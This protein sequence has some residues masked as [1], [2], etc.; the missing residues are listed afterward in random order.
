MRLATYNILHGRAVS[1][2]ASH[3]SESVADDPELLLKAIGRLDA[4]V[5]GLQEVD[6]F[7]PRSRTL[8]QTRLIAESLEAP[9]WR[10]VPTVIGTPGGRLGFRSATHTEIMESATTAAIPPEPEYGISLISRFPVSS[11]RVKVFPPAPFSLPLMV[12]SDRKP[13][14]VRVRDEQRAAIAAQVE[15]PLGRL[16]VVTAHLSF[17]PGFN[18]RQLRRLR[19]WIADMPRPLIL[20]GDFNLPGSVPRTTS[21]LT[22]LVT[23]PTFPS[24]RPRIQFDHIMADGFDE[25]EIEH[26]RS[27]VQ[28]WATGVSDHCAVT[29]D[30][31]PPLARFQ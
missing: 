28:T 31:P 16:T 29:V 9:E 6:K 13:Q 14:M 23:Q 27:S 17:V 24:Y 15:S 20:M 3:L 26:M 12:Q 11:W 21:R 4:D 2:S 22:E 7:Q 10:F 8:D 1:D 30:M 25:S 5:I 19:A 18:V